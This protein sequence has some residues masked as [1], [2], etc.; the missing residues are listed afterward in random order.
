MQRIILSDTS[1]LILLDKISNLSL[2][3]KVYGQVVVTPEI[4]FEFGKALPPWIEV[5]TPRNITFQKIL[6]ASLDKGEASALALALEQEDCLI[7]IDDL[8]GRKFAI[9]FGLK[10]TGTLGILVEAK[11]KGTEG[12]YSIGKTFISLFDG[13]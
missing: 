2:L 3:N 10:I 1:C 12:N 5:H 8:K 4:A 6:E 9:Q 13:Y 7:I 11:R